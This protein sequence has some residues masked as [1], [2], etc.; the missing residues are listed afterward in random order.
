MKDVIRAYRKG[1]RGA[2]HVDRQRFTIDLN[3][4]VIGEASTVLGKKLS[5]TFSLLMKYKIS[6]DELTLSAWQSGSYL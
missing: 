2:C 4:L 3:R 5:G 1:P 6:E